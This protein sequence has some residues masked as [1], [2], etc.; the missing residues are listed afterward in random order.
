M[1]IG[2]EHGDTPYALCTLVCLENGG[3]LRDVRLTYSEFNERVNR[4]ANGLLSL[5]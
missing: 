5:D 4:L 2:Y 3:C 1:E